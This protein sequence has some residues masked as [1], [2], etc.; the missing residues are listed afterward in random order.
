MLLR[1]AD[2][3]PAAIDEGLIEVFREAA[4]LVLLQP[5]IVA[6]L[7]ADRGD[8]VLYVL[9]GFA[10]AEIHSSFSL[11]RGRGRVGHDQHAA[12]TQLCDLLIAHTVLT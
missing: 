7:G 8:R 1:D 3:E 4:F 5:V 9:L 11:N 2:A 12:F 6:E 10:E